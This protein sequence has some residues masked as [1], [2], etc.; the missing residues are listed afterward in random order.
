MLGTLTRLPV[1]RLGWRLW[2]PKRKHSMSTRRRRLDPSD[3]HSHW[4]VTVRTGHTSA[5]VEQVDTNGRPIAAERLR[6]M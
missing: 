2:V 3:V 5:G 4:V 1:R 6:Y